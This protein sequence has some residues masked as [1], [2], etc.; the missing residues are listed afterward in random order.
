MS[1]R[2]SRCSLHWLTFI[3]SF[4]EIIFEKSINGGSNVTNIINIVVDCMSL[5]MQVACRKF[6]RC[7]V[8]MCDRKPIIITGNMLGTSTGTRICNVTVMLAGVGQS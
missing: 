6:I 5:E 7:C 8:I 1:A 2:Y 4:M 3:A